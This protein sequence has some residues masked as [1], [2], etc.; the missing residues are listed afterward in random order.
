MC[1]YIYL[2]IYIYIYIY[3]YR[4]ILCIGLYISLKL[5]DPFTWMGFNCPKAKERLRGDSLPFTSTQL[6]FTC[7]KSTIETLEKDVKYVQ[8]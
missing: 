6:T 5:L 4:L 2:N 3:I 1:I 7:L 8:S